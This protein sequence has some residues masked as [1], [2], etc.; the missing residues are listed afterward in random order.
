[1]SDLP[2]FVTIDD[3]AKHFKVSVST[4]RAWV[5]QGHIATW[6][7]VKL[8]N[9]YRFNL[10]KVVECLFP[11]ADAPQQ[12]ST[13]QGLTNPLQQPFETA[14]DFDLDADQDI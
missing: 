9:T 1:M 4:V 6:A 3:V 8:G 11:A 13:N 5:R 10:P 7:Y 2:E 12:S 14:L